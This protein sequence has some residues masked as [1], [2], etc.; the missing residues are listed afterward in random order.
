MAENLKIWHF[1]NMMCMNFQLEKLILQAPRPW[2]SVSSDL[3][4]S[5]Y[6]SIN[7]ASPFLSMTE[8]T[9]MVW[10][11]FDKSVFVTFVSLGFFSIHMLKKHTLN[12]GVSINCYISISILIKYSNFSRFYKKKLGLFY[13]KLRCDKFGNWSIS[14]K[15]LVPDG[16]RS[17]WAQKGS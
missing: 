15:N 8:A 1:W 7:G 10:G 14:T 3:G 9:S 4:H 16:S 13:K 17:R 12:P 11:G 2:N 5:S 6:Y